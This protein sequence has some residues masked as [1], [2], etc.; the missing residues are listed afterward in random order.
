MSAA[1]ETIY[2][3]KVR[4]RDGSLDGYVFDSLDHATEWMAQPF[5]VD[6][7]GGY[8]KV[9]VPARRDRRACPC[10][11][12]KHLVFTWRGKTKYA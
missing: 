1:V 4:D 7:P 9:T 8:E 10:C 2:V 12:T 5:V 11:N 3:L 6:D